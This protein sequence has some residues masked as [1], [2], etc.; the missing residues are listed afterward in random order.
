MDR[1]LEE[2]VKIKVC[3]M[4][5][6]R[7]ELLLTATAEGAG[8]EEGTSFEAHKTH[9]DESHPTSVCFNE[10]YVA[11]KEYL[12]PKVDQIKMRAMALLEALQ[13]L[14]GWKLTA[15]EDVIYCSV[16]TLQPV[17]PSLRVMEIEMWN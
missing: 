15:S 7:E 1:P 2:A 16:Q 17:T 12:S 3:M 14:L 11:G 9:S 4:C 13:H 6:A 10:L 5:R 8:W